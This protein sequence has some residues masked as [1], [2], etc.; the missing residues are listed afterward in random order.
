MPFDAESPKVG[1]E[2]REALLKAAELVEKGHCKH[3]LRVEKG[4]VTSFCVVGACCEAAGST[5]A[6]DLIVLTAKAAGLSYYE[7]ITWNNAPERTQAEVV[8]VLRKA[9]EGQEK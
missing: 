3:T 5:G 8:A 6:H 2:V 4:G 9:A 1:S 7:L